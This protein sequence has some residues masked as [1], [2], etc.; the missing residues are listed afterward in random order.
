MTL[1]VKTQQG[2]FER[3]FQLCATC[4]T[5]QDAYDQ[6]EEEYM[7]AMEIEKPRHATYDAFRM[8]KTRYYSHQ[9]NRKALMAKPK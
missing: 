2:Y 4:K 1:N 9:D 7:K 3:H 5:Q 8:A 6:L